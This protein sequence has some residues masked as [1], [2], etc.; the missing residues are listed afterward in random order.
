MR[1][2]NTEVNLDSFVISP[3]H[4]LMLY[5]AALLCCVFMQHLIVEY[6]DLLVF[7][8]YLFISTHHFDI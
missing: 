5:L 3:S 2:I 1:S 8:S 7:S 6:S 4:G